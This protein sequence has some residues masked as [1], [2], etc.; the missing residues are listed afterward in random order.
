LKGWLEGC[1]RNV[2]ESEV[3]E[4]LTRVIAGSDGFWNF[5]RFCVFAEVA[6]SGVG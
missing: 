3:K 2:L 1:V 4:G 5:G 6:A